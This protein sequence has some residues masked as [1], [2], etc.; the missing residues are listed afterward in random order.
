[1]ATT[2]RTRDGRTV[3]VKSAAERVTGRRGRWT[4]DG[5]TAE[6][7]PTKRAAHAIA[8]IAARSDHRLRRDLGDKRV[9]TPRHFVATG[10]KHATCGTES[11]KLSTTD[12]ARV[13]CPECTT[14]RDKRAAAA[15]AATSHQ[16]EVAALIDGSDD[17]LDQAAEIVAARVADEPVIPASDD[18][19]PARV[20]PLTSSFI[21]DDARNGLQAICWECGGRIVAYPYNAEYRHLSDAVE[22]AHGEAL[23]LDAARDLPPVGTEPDADAEL[24]GTA[25]ERLTM[26]IEDAHAAALAEERDRAVRARTADPARFTEELTTLEDMRRVSREARAYDAAARRAGGSR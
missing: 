25:W 11:P 24:F 10:I 19:H 23:A 13:T 16:S 5:W 14:E 18:D 1:M 26:P 2:Y 22:A 6:T 7:W 8:V 15:R 12:W 20:R 9:P 21:N 3:T 17:A 4:V